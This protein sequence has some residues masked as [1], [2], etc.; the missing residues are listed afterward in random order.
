[1][2]EGLMT[3]EAVGTEEGLMTGEAV[4]TEKGLMTG[5]AVG[6]K[7]SVMT[8]DAVGTKEEVMTGDSVSGKRMEAERALPGGGNALLE[9]IK[10]CF[11]GKEQ[12]IRTYS[13]LTLAYIGDVVYDLIIRTVVVE[14]ANR[15]V[16]ELHRVTVRY[17]SANAQSRIVQALQDSLTEEEKSVYRRGKNAKPHTMAKNASPADY[18][19]ATGFEAVVGYLYLTGRMERVLELVKQGIELAGLEL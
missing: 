10:M 8:G 6:T 14:R 1:M 18:L 3:G 13:P 7:E 16:N 4:G 5:D 17:V 15:P 2:E 9:E 19:K 11:P 12:D